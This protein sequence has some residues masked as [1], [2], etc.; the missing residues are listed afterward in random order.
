MRR[1]RGALIPWRWLPAATVA[2]VAVGVLLGGCATRGP[3]WQKVREPIP[4][5]ET[6]Y[7]LA[8]CGRASLGGCARLADGIREIK[9]G[10]PAA[11]T[12]CVLSHEQHHFDGYD[13]PEF[14][15]SDAFDKFASDCGDGTMYA[16]G[17]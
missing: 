12:A 2:C 13:H 3:Y 9:R 5:K 7:V 4:I 8:P 15:S 6:R 14:D 1:T 16:S 10:M 17:W 11:Q